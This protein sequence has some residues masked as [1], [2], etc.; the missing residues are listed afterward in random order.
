VFQERKKKQIET[1]QK[2]AILK[3]WPFKSSLKFAAL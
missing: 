3:K 1:L 2:I